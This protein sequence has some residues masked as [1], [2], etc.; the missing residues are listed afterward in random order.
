[1]RLGIHISTSGDSYGTPRRAA[2]LGWEAAQ[3][4][5]SNQRR[6]KGRELEERGVRRFRR[7]SS[8]PLISHA[9]YL[10]NLASVR[11]DV[12]SKSRR[13]L[14]EELE[15]SAALGIPWVV[16]HP[17]A[18]G[19][20][21]ERHGLRL[22]AEGIAG[23]L[24][25]LRDSVGLLLEN[26]A[27]QGTSLGRDFEQLAVLL[28]MIGMPGSTGACLDTAHAF[29]AGYDLS[30]GAKARASVTAILRTLGRH[31][32]VTLH[33]NDSAS[34]MASGSDRH[35]SPGSGMIGVGPLAAICA[36][37]ELEDAIGIVETPGSDEDRVADAARLRE[38]AARRG[39]T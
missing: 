6:W 11:M 13:A 35:A 18:H 22:V 8:I 32:L 26:S 1:M 15:R 25:G 23:A 17:G 10:I 20:R 33:L 7:L 27:G 14:R 34:A 4:F 2:E 5:T 31:R 39:G 21:G 29:A 28:D 19:G 36:M 12:R 30:S 37:S 16:L 3:L 38:R 24:D 9:S